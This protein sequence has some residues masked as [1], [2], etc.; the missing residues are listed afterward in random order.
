MSPIL[1][2]ISKYE[3]HS[4]SHSITVQTRMIWHLPIC[5]YVNYCVLWLKV[6]WWNLV[7]ITN[8]YHQLTTGACCRSLFFSICCATF[9]VIFWLS[10]DLSLLSLRS[11]SELF[12]SAQSESDTV[13]SSVAL[14][15]AVLYARGIMA[16]HRF[17]ILCSLSWF[18]DLSKR[19]ALTCTAI[20]EIHDVLWVRNFST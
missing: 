16:F 1:S 14:F 4:Y 10:S 15:C 11:I 17:Y 18:D 5:D 12:L 9:V 6:F 8:K 13:S 19:V 7:W 20:T 2:D 3:S